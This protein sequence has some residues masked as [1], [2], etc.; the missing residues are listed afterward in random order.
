MPQSAL[1]IGGGDGGSAEEL[2]EHNTIQSVELVEIDQA[3]IDFSRSYLRGINHG[4]MDVKGG[5]PRLEILVADGL[6]YMQNSLA[7]YDLMIFDLTD[8]GGPSQPLYTAAF[9][10]HCAA[11]LKP[12]GLLS[13]QVASPF[14]QAERVLSTLSDMARAFS[15]VRPYMVSIPL[16]GGQWMTAF[17]SQSMDPATLAIAQA[18]AVIRNRSLTSLQHYNGHTHQAAMALPNFVRELV[19]P[20]GALWK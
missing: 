11:R 14:A 12:G 16:S 20:T 8:P 15:V 19:K 13:L 3:V 6:Q 1:I 17:A 9:Y 10:K 18:D 2:L 5:D 4:V 7:M